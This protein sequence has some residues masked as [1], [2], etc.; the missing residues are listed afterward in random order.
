M[1]YDKPPLNF[2]QQADRLLQR[3]LKADRTI[4]IKRLQSVN[5]YRLS[6]YLYPFRQADETFRKGTSLDMV[7][8]NYCFDRQLRLLIMDGCEHFETALKTDIVYHLAHQCGG[9]GY[10]EAK[11]LPGISADTHNKLLEK[12]K[13]ETKR[14]K[15]IFVSHF[16]AK[17]GD[18][19][20]FLPLWMAAEVLSFG[21]LHTM[22]RGL[23]SKLK[24]VIAGN[25]KI[26]DKVL[27]SWIGTIQVIRNICAHHGRIYN[28]ILGVKPLIPN[29]DLLWHTPQTIDNSRVFS[30]VS[31]LNYLIKTIAPQSEWK[32]QLFDLLKKHK[33]IPRSVMGFHSGWRNNELWKDLK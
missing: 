32:Q 33:K 10:L 7:W 5:Y 16:F 31:I 21:S 23:H 26:A 8:E 29:K 30:I 11:N 3:G 22:Y 20:N 2:E 17:Y 18:E 27:L 15:E 1:K 25:Y 13:E 24:Q 28:R 12:I 14:S 4:L 19:H 9:F 6:G